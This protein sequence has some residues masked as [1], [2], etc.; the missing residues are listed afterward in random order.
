[1]HHSFK[2]LEARYS[3]S[4]RADFAAIKRFEAQEESLREKLQKY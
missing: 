3:R 2:A 1:M 4:Q